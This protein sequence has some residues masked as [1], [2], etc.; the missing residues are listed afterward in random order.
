MLFDALL[1]LWATTMTT[2]LALLFLSSLFNKATDTERFIGFLGNYN[3]LPQASLNFFTYCLMACEFLIVTLLLVP[4]ANKL[5]ASIAI[6]ILMLYASVIAINVFRGNLGIECGCGGPP[7]HLSYGLVFRNLA[8]A[9]M[10]LPLLF[11][12]DDPIAF[13]DIAVAVASGALLYLFYLASE[14]LLAN[15]NKATHPDLLQ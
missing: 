15:L 8:I 13:I 14:Q 5:G 11:R 12:I 7:I 9:G 6:A 10:A 3:L 4:Q 1:K 2:F